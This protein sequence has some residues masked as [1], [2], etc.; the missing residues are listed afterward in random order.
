[1]SDIQS[2]SLL[3]PGQ[4]RDEDGPVFSEPWQAQAFALT[5]KLH[6]A[7]CFSW[8]EWTERLGAEFRAAADSGEPDDG[9]HYYEH[10]LMALEKLVAEKGMVGLEAIAGRARDWEKAYLNTP[11]GKPVHLEAA[12]K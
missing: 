12:K 7:G 5:V 9:S 8:K 4:P 6:E 3:T 10:W 2:A 1:M 11:H